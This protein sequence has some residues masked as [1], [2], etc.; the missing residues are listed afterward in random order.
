MW[1]AGSFA[2]VRGLSGCGTWAPEPVGLVV[3]VY[4]VGCS[5]ACGIKPALLAL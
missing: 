5:T 2:A 1:Q 3:G 4:G